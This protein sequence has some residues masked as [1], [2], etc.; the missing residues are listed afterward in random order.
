MI[1]EVMGRDAG[2]IALN[3]GIAGGVDVI[4][5]PE[6]P[7]RIE[8]VAAQLRDLKEKTGR[9]HA[10]VVCAEAI[11]PA[12]GGEF[13]RQCTSGAPYG[14]VGHR[15]GAEIAA[16]TGAETR[17][18]L[19]GHVQ[20]GGTPSSRDRIIASAFGVRAVDILAAG[21]RDRMVAWCNRG[22]VIDIALADVV[23]GAQAVELD[24]ALVQT[25][26]GIGISFGD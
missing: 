17:V 25:A 10:L 3:A 18:T 1:L 4:L 21:Q 5:I 16:A 11:R 8:R 24:S 14:G 20:R 6:I 12:S 23:V 26:R 13:V 7:Y 2:Y 22:G 9:N 15:L 19:L